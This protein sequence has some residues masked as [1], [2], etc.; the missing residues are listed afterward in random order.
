MRKHPT[1]RDLFPRLIRFSWLATQ[2]PV[3]AVRAVFLPVESI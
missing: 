1:Q 2:L 3:A